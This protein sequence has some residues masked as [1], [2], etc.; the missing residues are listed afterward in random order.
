VFELHQSREGE[1]LRH[2]LWV[3][4]C[5]DLATDKVNVK[6]SLS[7][8]VGP[9]LHGMARPPVAD[10]GKASDMEGTCE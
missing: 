6:V 2:R 3:D 5:G 8:N 4:F 10:G 7:M 1:C 9:C